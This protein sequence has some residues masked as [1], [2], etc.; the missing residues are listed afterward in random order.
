MCVGV[1]FKR[2]CFQFQLIEYRGE[3]LFLRWAWGPVFLSSTV[4]KFSLATLPLSHLLL[5]HECLRGIDWIIFCRILANQNFA[6]AVT[7]ELP[8]LSAQ[9]QGTDDSPANIMSLRI[10]FLLGFSS[11]E[12]LMLNDQRNLMKGTDI[13]NVML[14]SVSLPSLQTFPSFGSLQ[15]SQ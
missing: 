8:F 5:I 14:T 2:D 9:P 10:H 7:L 1:D 4:S 12:S 3:F 15:T 13:W 11:Y 6:V